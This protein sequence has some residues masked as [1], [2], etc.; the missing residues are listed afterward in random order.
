MKTPAAPYPDGSIDG[1]TAANVRAG[2]D[3]LHL[4]ARRAGDGFTGSRILSRAPVRY[5]CVEIVARLPRGR[6]F[7]PALWLRTPYDGTPING[8]IDMMEG[9]GS[10]PGVFMSTLHHWRN[11]IDG[12][13]A[14][15]RPVGE[16]GRPPNCAKVVADTPR[17]SAETKWGLLAARA[18]GNV[19][20]DLGNW[21]FANYQNQ[22]AIFSVNK[23][24][25]FSED[26][27]K[28]LLVWMPGHL[29]WVLDGRTYF[30]IADDVPDKAM[31]I[32]MC[33]SVGSLDGGANGT[34]P[35][36]GDFQIK[37]VRIMDLRRP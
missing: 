23:N 28:Y 15:R 20:S 2:T 14:P 36:S 21:L 16:G 19:R 33:L 35:A 4:M 8:E 17:S 31:M 18:S 32:V 5:G 13:S 34:T 30:S 9:F 22:C 25:D 24:I 12:N 37:S 26:F 7:W 1:D 3:A 6:G 29:I 11:G 10:H 27:H